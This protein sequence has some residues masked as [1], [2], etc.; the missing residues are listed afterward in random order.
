MKFLSLEGVQYLW[1]KVTDLVAE[2]K[3]TIDAYTINGYKISENP[4]LNKSD[5]G[6]GNVD[7]TSDLNKP[8][9]TA[10]QTA[11]DKK[12]DKTTTINGYALSSNVTLS[13]SDVGLGNV[14][15]TA[16]VDK[17][18]S[19]AQKTYIDGLVGDL[20]SNKVDK[21]TTINGYALSGN[22]TLTKSDVGL[23]NVTN[24]AQVKRSEMG[25]AGG[26]ATL[27][28]SGL[29]PASQL[30][31]YVDDVVEVYATYTINEDG[32]FSDIALY[33]DSDH[34]T[35]ITGE[36][37]KIYQNIGGT[38]YQFRYTGSSYAVVGQP[39]VIGTVTGTA[40]DGAKGQVAYKHAQAK[41]AAFSSGLYKIT[42]NAQGHVTAATAVV[43]TDITNLGIPAQDTTYTLPTATASV[44]GGIKLGSGTAQTVAANSVTATASRTYAIQLNSSS[45]AVVN[46]PWIEDT[47]LSTDELDTVLV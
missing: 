7:N 9:S 44:L 21:T 16:D 35:A 47:A 24:D 18:V 36:T 19:T 10:Q 12:V 5:V 28:S 4:T 14:D 40:F 34:T 22:V 1:G 20:D 17:P 32:T 45:Q 33:S 31:S 42:T 8:V 11:L 26:V 13:A 23:S 39:T 38:S 29:V 46:V 41:G 43:K 15:N 27:D 30:P 25:V 2:T 3:S 6:L 37:G